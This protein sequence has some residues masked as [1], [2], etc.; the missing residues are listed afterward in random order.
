MS[1]SRKDYNMV[2][3]KLDANIYKQLIKYCEKS[4]YTKTAV[5]ENALEEYLKQQNKK[6][7]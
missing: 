7:N 2:G 5:I 1:R 4:R 3:I 6:E